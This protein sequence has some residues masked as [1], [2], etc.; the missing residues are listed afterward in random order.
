LSRSRCRSISPGGVLRLFSVEGK[1]RR[2]GIP[3]DLIEPDPYS[4]PVRY[5]AKHQKTREAH[6]SFSVFLNIK[7]ERKASWSPRVARFAGYSAWNEC[8]TAA[9]RT[10]DTG[11]HMRGGFSSWSRHLKGTC[12]HVSA[13]RQSEGRFVLLRNDPCASQKRISMSPIIVTAGVGAGRQLK[14]ARG[15]EA[16]DADADAPLMYSFQIDWASPLL[17]LFH[18]RSPTSPRLS[19]Q[20]VRQRVLV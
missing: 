12:L 17:S 13:H 6:P 4:L 1:G 9:G 7:P 2:W 19:I 10:T 20:R 11:H 16:S 3:S 8:G 5:E 15:V 14:N 18:S